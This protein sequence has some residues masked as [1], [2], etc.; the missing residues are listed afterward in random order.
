MQAVIEEIVAA[1]GRV[2]GLVNNAGYGTY[3]AVEEVPMDAV[4]PSSRRTS[5]GWPG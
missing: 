1:H 2:G 4:R 5:S 3:G